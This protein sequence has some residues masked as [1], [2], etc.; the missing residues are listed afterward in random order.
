MYSD[1]TG[2]FLGMK[3]DGFRVCLGLDFFGVFFKVLFGW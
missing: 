3:C 2:L 1:Y